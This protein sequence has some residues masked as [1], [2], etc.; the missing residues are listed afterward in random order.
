MNKKLVYYSIFLVSIVILTIGVVNISAS[1][2]PEAC[3]MPFN[4]ATCNDLFDGSCTKP[5]GCWGNGP[6]LGTNCR[7]SC[8]SY[9]FNASGLCVMVKIDVDCGSMR[10]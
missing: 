2:P 1:I 6:I 10:L 9:Q 7:I 4:E 8:W 5:G 3:L